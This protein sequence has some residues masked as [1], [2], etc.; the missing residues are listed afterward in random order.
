MEYSE[1]WGIGKKYPDMEILKKVPQ[2]HRDENG[3]KENIG[4]PLRS[5]PIFPEKQKY[6]TIRT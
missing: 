4:F 6:T 1:E 3:C 2:H 5:K